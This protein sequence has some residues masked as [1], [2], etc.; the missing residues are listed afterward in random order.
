MSRILRNYLISFIIIGLFFLAVHLIN[1]YV[2]GLQEAN[3]PLPAG[4]ST[5]EA[6]QGG[7]N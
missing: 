3:S 7:K 1:K 6:H 4:S 2:A 5:E